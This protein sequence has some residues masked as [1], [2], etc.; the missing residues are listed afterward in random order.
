VSPREPVVDF[1]VSTFQIQN[2]YKLKKHVKLYFRFIKH[3]AWKLWRTEPSRSSKP[4]P[5]RGM[6]ST[7]PWSGCPTRYKTRNRKKLFLAEKEIFCYFYLNFH[8]LIQT[9]P[10][11]LLKSSWKQ[12]QENSFQFLTSSIPFLPYE[13]E[14]FSSNHF[15][16]FF[17]LILSFEIF[18]VRTASSFCYY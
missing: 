15:S 8:L 13:E 1:A 10:Q 16:N 12:T 6:A 9:H 2:V 11:T 17:L 5:S 3:S 18:H 14:A 4:A 7:R